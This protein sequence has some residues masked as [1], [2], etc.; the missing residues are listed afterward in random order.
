MGAAITTPPW[1]PPGHFYSPLTAAADVERALAWKAI[2]GRDRVPGV[3]L[4]ETEQIALALSLAEELDKP[5]EGPRYTPSNPMF[6]AAD[7]AVYRS[8]LR[9]HRPGRVMEIG[10]GFSTALA[11]DTIDHPAELT[12]VEP[13]PDRLLALLR[14]GDEERLTLLRSPVQ[15]VPLS[16]YE[17]LESGDLLFI[18]STHVVKAGSD[19]LWLFLQVLPRLAPGVLVHVHDVF[20]PFDYPDGWLREGRDWTENYLLH[21]FLVGNAGYEILLFSSWLWQEH[22]ELVPDGISAESPGS[23]WLRRTG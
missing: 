20:W 23:I 3:D 11:L 12:C 16:A 19:V 2:P 9:H 22:G 1:M 10:S 6:N 4:R 21:A 18:D 5:F 15:D 8:M 13:Y 7:A 17:K 14:P